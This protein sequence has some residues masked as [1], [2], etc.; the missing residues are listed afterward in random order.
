M[1]RPIRKATCSI[2]GCW[3]IFIGWSIQTACVFQ[4]SALFN[5]GY[6]SALVSAAGATASEL[7]LDG[8]P[9]FHAS[10]GAFFS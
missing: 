6:L 5:K 1:R 3:A 8:I 4:F 2:V 7:L 9:R 10:L